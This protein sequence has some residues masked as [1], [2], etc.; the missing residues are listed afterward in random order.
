MKVMMMSVVK[1]ASMP[2]TFWL[3]ENFLSSSFK[4][5]AQALA[6]EFG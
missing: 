5:S 1:R 6:Q 3:L 4:E 2:V